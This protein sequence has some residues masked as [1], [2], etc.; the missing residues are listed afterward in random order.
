MAL[1][2]GSFAGGLSQGL[3]EGQD[4]RRKQM[5]M[6]ATRRM[7]AAQAAAGAAG[8]QGGGQPPPAQPPMG[9][10]VAPPGG[11]GTP[12]PLPQ[13]APP[14][15]TP[16]PQAQ[17]APQPKPPAPM[18]QPQGGPPKPPMAAPPQGAAPGG[19]SPAGGD[20]GGQILND[21]A[22]VQTI[23]Q[24]QQTLQ[25]LYKTLLAANPALKHD[26]QTAFQAV[27]DMIGQMKGVDQ[28]DRNLMLQQNQIL[29]LQ[30]QLAKDAADRG[31][32]EAIAQGRDDTSRANNQDTNDTRVRTTGMNNATSRANVA[33]RDSTSV[34]TTGMRD[35]TQ[36]QT[37]G[38]R[39]DTQ[40]R[41]TD[42]RDTTSSRNTDVRDRGA[43]GRQD[44]RN[45][46]SR[47]NSQDRI[48]RPL[49]APLGGGAQHTSP[50][51]P[52]T[53]EGQTATSPNGDKWVVKGGKWVM[54]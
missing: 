15:A 4:L 33:D 39:D 30:V 9:Q 13:G 20:Q 3:E 27:E 52:A 10:G 29:R 11:G 22:V 24:S 23:Q 54:Q 48:R 50:P 5:E 31:S 7:N 47:A 32:R 40:E 1:S 28:S 16:M 6:E 41:D 8:M 19:Q 37:T 14:G 35:S 25:G 34:Q 38:M 53:T 21:P 18:T 17:A 43:T 12:R 51:F 49:K 2:L 36:V 45:A 26:P 46:T 44:S 42:A